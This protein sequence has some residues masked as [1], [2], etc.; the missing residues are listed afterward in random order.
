M[1]FT[2]AKL[3]SHNYL[4]AKSS[5]VRLKTGRIIVT[6]DLDFGEIVGLS[7]A[8]GSGSC[9]CGSDWLVKIIC[10]D[11]FARPLPRRDRRCKP[12]RSFWSKTLASVSGGCRRGVERK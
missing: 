4:I 1:R 7:G 10:A 3:G 2:F 12:A 9:C 8:A 6:F 11:G 5:L